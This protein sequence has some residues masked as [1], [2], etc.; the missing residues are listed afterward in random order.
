MPQKREKPFGYQCDCPN[1]RYFSEQSSIILQ[2]TETTNRKICYRPAEPKMDLARSTPKKHAALA[3]KALSMAGATPLYRAA[4][5][6]SLSRVLNTGGTDGWFGLLRKRHGKVAKGIGRLPNVLRKSIV[7]STHLEHEKAPPT[8]YQIDAKAA[9]P[10]ELRR[11][12]ITI[13]CFIFCMRWSRLKVS[14]AFHVGQST[15]KRPP[16][17]L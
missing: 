10:M 7:L 12:T 13:S 3:G 9:T 2:Q 8:T 1:G 15:D 6:S 5:P 11:P 4:A 14:E 16:W 17:T